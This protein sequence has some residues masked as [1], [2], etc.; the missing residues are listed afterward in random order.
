VSSSI[1]SPTQ[2]NTESRKDVLT[3]DL[4]LI[5]QTLQ[6]FEQRTNLTHVGH[7]LQELNKS[8]PET[9]KEDTSKPIDLSPLVN[10]LI[11]SSPFDVDKKEFEDL[12][13]SNLIQTS[14]VDGDIVAGNSDL[15]VGELPVLDL[16]S[17]L[18]LSEIINSDVGDIVSAST[19]VEKVLEQFSPVDVDTI[20]GVLQQEIMD[21]QEC[22]T[23]LSNKTKQQEFVEMK[24]DVISQAEDVS[25]DRKQEVESNPKDLNI[26]E[27]VNELS[28][29]KDTASS[30]QNVG[31]KDKLGDNVVETGENVGTLDE[32]T[33]LKKS[34]QGEIEFPD[35]PNNNGNL[36]STSQSKNDDV[37]SVST[38]DA[39]SEISQ[40]TRNTS[41][42]EP[43]SSESCSSGNTSSENIKT[44]ENKQEP[45]VSESILGSEVKNRENQVNTTGEDETNE[46]IISSTQEKSNLTEVLDQDAISTTTQAKKSNLTEI[47]DQDAISTTTQV[48]K[49]NLT[50][51]LD[52]DATSTTTQATTGSEEIEVTEGDSNNDDGKQENIDEQLSGSE[53][54]SPDGN[55]VRT[56]NRKRKAPPPRDLSVH[57]PGWVRSALQ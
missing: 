37:I 12:D 47:L 10:E 16:D 55:L 41:D 29:L 34:K 20:D 19:A 43:A 15:F 28:S 51:V 6:D 44:T 36:G 33:L 46:M 26:T 52:Q 5:Q 56:S 11:S 23:N 3:S 53:F 50:E 57:P 45:A 39:T 42:K 38:V 48:K 22:T 4:D 25:S 24:K 8:N 27:Q 30:E 49:S 35:F 1:F 18:T 17:D 2:D 14:T 31:F 21:L 9:G 54:V 7:S 13:P 40:D 32:Q